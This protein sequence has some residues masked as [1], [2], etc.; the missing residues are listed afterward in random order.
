MLYARHSLYNLSI[1]ESYKPSIP[2]IGIGNLAFGGSGKS[3]FA[4]YLAEFFLSKSFKVAI[5]S[6]GYKRSTAGVLRCNANHTAKEIGDEPKMYVSKL[7]N[8][9]VIVAEKRKEGIQFL[10]ELSNPP[11][12]ILLDDCYQHRAIS[13]DLLLLLSELKKPYWKD[14]LVPSG[15]L[16]DVKGAAKRADALILTKCEEPE[17]IKLPTYWESKPVFYSHISYETPVHLGIS[18]EVNPSVVCFSALADD[19]RFKAYLDESFNLIKAFSFSDHH[20]FSDS[21]IKEIITA[22]QNKH[23]ILTTEKDYARLTKE[24]L[25]ALSKEHFHIIPIST[26]VKAAKKFEEYILTSLGL[27]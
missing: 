8:V 25:A 10:Q 9:T 13:P 7:P 20:Y 1:L 26:P 27:K 16:R 22:S 21:E 19:S 17:T 5:V 14:Y 3:P 23:S 24:Q 6:R 2:S 15:Y 4:I 12:V 11:D 18:T